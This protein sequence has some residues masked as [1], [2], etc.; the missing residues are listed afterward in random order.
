MAGCTGTNNNNGA[1][2]VLRIALAMN[3]GMDCDVVIVN[4]SGIVHPP[5]RI[6]DQSANGW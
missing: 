5:A 6:A 3:K 2:K 4:A 1:F